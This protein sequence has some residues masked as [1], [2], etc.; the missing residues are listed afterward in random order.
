MKRHVT[1]F[2]LLLT[3]TSGLLLWSCDTVSDDVLPNFFKEFKLY[4]DEIY[5]VNSNS[6]FILRLDPL[7]NDSIKTEV[8]VTYSQPENGELLPDF[9]GPGTMGYEPHDGFFGIDNLTYTVCVDKSCQTENI[10]LIVETPQDP[11]TCVTVLHGETLETTVN[12]SRQ[13]R[14]FLNDVICYNSTYGGTTIYKPEKGTFET[15]EYAGSY[16]NTIYVYIPP[17]DYI[18]QDSFKYRVYTNPD[19]SVYQEITV[20]VTIR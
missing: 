7:A 16:K 5:T 14:I 17:K 8:N 10:K 9:D 6:G 3:V 20:P 18:G 11:A 12:T 15:I 13:L 4:P 2:I 1:R 19:R